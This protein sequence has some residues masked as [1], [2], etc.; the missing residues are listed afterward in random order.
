MMTTPETSAEHPDK[1]TQKLRSIANLGKNRQR[2]SLTDR[3]LKMHIVAMRLRLSRNGKPM[4][5]GGGACVAA[6]QCPHLSQM[7]RCANAAC[8]NDHKATGDTRALSASL[9]SDMCPT[10]PAPPCCG[11]LQPPI[12]RMLHIMGESWLQQAMHP[13]T[14]PLTTSTHTNPIHTQANINMI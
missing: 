10:R 3:S 9:V 13:R 8:I 11:H 2:M 7:Q 4:R 12:S 5:G 14:S 1:H 6:A